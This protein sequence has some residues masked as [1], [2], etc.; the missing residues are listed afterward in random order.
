[1]DCFDIH[2]GGLLVCYESL[3]LTFREPANCS[4]S[5]EYMAYM[6]IPLKRPFLLETE[7]QEAKNVSYIKEFELCYFR[8]FQMMAY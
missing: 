6:E 5:L 1:M 4:F 7:K 3:R 2:R 8:L